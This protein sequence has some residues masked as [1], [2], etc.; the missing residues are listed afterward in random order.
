MWDFGLDNGMCFD[1][2]YACRSLFS[3]TQHNLLHPLNS[4]WSCYYSS[5][6]RTAGTEEAAQ[7]KG[8][9]R[10]CHCDPSLSYTRSWEGVVLHVHVFNPSIQGTELSVRLRPDRAIECLKTNCLRSP[11]TAI[12]WTMRRGRECRTRLPH[13]IFE[14]GLAEQVVSQK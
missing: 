3:R 2:T 13:R 8:A 10:S 7:K 1:G 4:V 14:W 5:Q 11:V 12:H 6:F 9:W